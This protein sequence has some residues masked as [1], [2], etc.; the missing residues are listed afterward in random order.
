MHVQEDFILGDDG[1]E[2]AEKKWKFEHVILSAADTPE[3][4]LLYLN[5]CGIKHLVTLSCPIICPRFLQLAS[6]THAE[7][8]A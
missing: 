1:E 4:L 3:R 6:Y 7:M 8:S 5:Q 2:K